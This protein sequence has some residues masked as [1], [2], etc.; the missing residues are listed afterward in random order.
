M[1]KKLML[2]VEQPE[3]NLE[4]AMKTLRSNLIYSGEKTD[5]VVVTSVQPSEGKSTVAFCW[6]KALQS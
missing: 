1:E 4:E 6:P 5:V 3:R 2:A